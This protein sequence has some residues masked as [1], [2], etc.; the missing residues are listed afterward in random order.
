MNSFDYFSG[1]SIPETKQQELEFLNSIGCSKNT[2]KAA[3]NEIEKILIRK[4]IKYYRNTRIK[5]DNGKY[6]IPDFETDDYFI[7]VKSKGYFSTG[8][9]SEKIDC[10]PRKYSKLKKKYLVILCAA[11]IR[12]NNEIL[13]Q[14]T[15]YAESFIKTAERFGLIGFITLRQF[16]S[17]CQP[18]IK[19]VGG[20]SK[21]L[22]EI[23]ACYDTALINEYIE[24][25][26]GG[27]SVFINLLNSLNF[28]KLDRIVCNDINKHLIDCYLDIK[29]NVTE[30]IQEIEKTKATDAESYYKLRDEFNELTQTVR[31]SAL[32]IVLNKTCFRGLYRENKSGKFNVPY[33][34][35]YDTY[36]INT[37]NLIGLCFLFNFYGV[38]FS[39]LD[40]SEILCQTRSNALVFCDPPYVKLK[41]NT[42]TK[43]TKNDFGIDENLKLA[44]ILNDLNCNVISCNHYNET[45]DNEY[46]KTFNK[47][48]VTVTRQINSKSPGTKEIEV[49]YW[50]AAVF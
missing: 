2:G 38:E 49:I 25:F 28:R 45:L 11:E 3:E 48:Y 50:K 26:L 13:N 18:F 40:Y 9:A 27:G 33:G 47:K 34:N 35:Y 6:L 39:S 30:L 36:T 22:N 46:S 24:P 8:T 15:E 20:K 10:I 41:N 44:G 16:G 1:K 4:Q 17:D 12:D 42:F 21:L 29:N 32:F 5:L 14:T 37:E 43:Y 7:E 31:K 19:Y 23:T